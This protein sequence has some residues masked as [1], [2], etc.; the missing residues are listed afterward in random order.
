MTL[1]IPGLR[2]LTPDTSNVVALLGIEF[3]P[4]SHKKVAVGWPEAVPSKLYI[5]SVMHSESL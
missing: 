5:P 3:E 4:K 1:C 2:Y